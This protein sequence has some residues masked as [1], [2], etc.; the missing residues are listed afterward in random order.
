MQV[1]QKIPVTATGYEAR[2]L[3]FILLHKTMKRTRGRDNSYLERN[4]EIP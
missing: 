1:V 3:L 4:A 2:N